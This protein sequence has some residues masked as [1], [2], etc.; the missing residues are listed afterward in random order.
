MVAFV[1]VRERLR[2]RATAYQQC[3]LGD[4]G[5]PHRAGGLVLADLRRFCRATAPAVQMAPD[6]RVDPLAS[7]LAEGRREVWLRIAKHLNLTDREIHQLTED[8]DG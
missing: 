8:E 4:R 3:F 5:E 2:R 6:G 1:R 7:M